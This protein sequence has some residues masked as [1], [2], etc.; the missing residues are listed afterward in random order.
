MTDKDVRHTPDHG[1]YNG[2]VLPL[3]AY[4]NLLK[5]VEDIGATHFYD[6]AKSSN[7]ETIPFQQAIE[8]IERTRPGARRKYDLIIQ[9]RARQTLALLPVAAYDTAK[10]VILE[11]RE[12]PRASSQKLKERDGW[13]IDAKDYV[14]I[15]EI[16]DPQKIVTILHIGHCNEVY[17]LPVPDDSIESE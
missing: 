7:E 15:F 1:S 10:D 14:V 5:E 9:D 12:K 3:K 2:P 16:N 11:L 17:R 6:H 8:E 13:R 4:L